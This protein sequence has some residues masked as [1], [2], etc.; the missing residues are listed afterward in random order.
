MKV[1]TYEVT[2]LT[3]DGEQPLMDEQS[4]ALIEELGL[5]GQRT[6]ITERTVYGEDTVTTINPYR[7]ITREESNVFRACFPMETAVER[8][9]GGMIPLRVL[10]VIAHARTALPRNAKLVVWHP[11]DST[12]RDPVLVA[13]PTDGNHD[14]KTYLLARWG[15]ALDTMTTLKTMARQKLRASSKRALAEAKSKIAVFEAT[16]EAQIDAHLEGERTE[17]QWLPN[18]VI[19]R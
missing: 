15:E 6:F 8:Y 18:L 17:S 4:I 14:T 3:T 2:E 9:E 10:Q 5:N 13:V 1:E 11:E 12:T 16:L 7:L 19:G